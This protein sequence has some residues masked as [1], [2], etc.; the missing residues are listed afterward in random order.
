[1]FQNEQR[2]ASSF[3][4]RIETETIDREEQESEEVA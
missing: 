1:M 3:I 2:K 4:S